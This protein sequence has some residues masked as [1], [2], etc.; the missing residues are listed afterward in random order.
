M[1]AYMWT[2][3]CVCS[4]G[5]SKALREELRQKEE[6]LQAT[7]QQVTMLSAELR[8]SS[9]TRDRSMAELYRVKLEAD[10]LRQGQAE[11]RADCSRLEK[12]V[13]EMKKSATQ[14]AVSCYPLWQSQNSCSAFVQQSLGAKFEFTVLQCNSDV[15]AS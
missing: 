14:E 5:E 12:Q 10:T 13:E 9:S 15:S 6:Q 4:K 1:L 8:D 3:V 11:A 2:H 7:Q